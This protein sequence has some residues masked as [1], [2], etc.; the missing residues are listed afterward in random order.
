MWPPPEVLLYAVLECCPFRYCNRFY[1]L[2]A[3]SVCLFRLEQLLSDLA[4]S[5]SGDTF[6]T[7][8]LAEP[9][10]VFMSN[11]RLIPGGTCSV[12]WEGGRIIFVGPPLCPT[13]TLI[14]VTREF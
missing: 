6:P 11:S 3:L 13:L 10:I 5:F 7:V 12:V 4:D 14:V 1:E 8:R 9:P 2:L